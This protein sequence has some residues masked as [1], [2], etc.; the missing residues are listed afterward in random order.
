MFNPLRIMLLLTVTPCPMK[1]VC[2]AAL[3]LFWIGMQVGEVS[4]RAVGDF[5]W[6]WSGHS[7]PLLGLGLETE[8]DFSPASA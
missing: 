7:L 5:L 1:V 6:F 2:V 3:G 4:N 8:S